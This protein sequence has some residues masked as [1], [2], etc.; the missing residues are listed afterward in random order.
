[1]ENKTRFITPA[2]ML[3]AGAIAAIIMFIRGF[4]LTRMLWG[5]LIVLVIFY[6][7]GDIARYLYSTIRPRIIP[8]ADLDDMVKIAR[9][10]AEITGNVVEFADEAENEDEESENVKSESEEG[11]SGENAADEDI[12]EEY[13]DEDLEGS[14]YSEE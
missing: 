5:L 7:L 11:I 2:L 3:L 1:M 9:Q 6:I 13:G 4:E 12:S 8:D 10:N 14:E